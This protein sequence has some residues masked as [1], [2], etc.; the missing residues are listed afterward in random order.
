MALL[1]PA[2][3]ISPLTQAEARRRQLADLE[4]KSSKRLSSLQGVAAKIRQAGARA[5]DW[6]IKEAIVDSIVCQSDRP[7]DTPHQLS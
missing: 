5:R 3:Q 2:A 4:F 1:A 6:S 7:I